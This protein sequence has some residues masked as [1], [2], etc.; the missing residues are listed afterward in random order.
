MK[1]LVSFIMWRSFLWGSTTDWTRIRHRV[2]ESE[3]LAEKHVAYFQLF[4]STWRNLHKLHVIKTLVENTERARG[5]G[6]WVCSAYAGD[7]TSLLLW[8]HLH[9]WW[10]FLYPLHWLDQNLG[11][12]L[13]FKSSLTSCYTGSSYTLAVN[14]SSWVIWWSVG[15]FISFSLAVTWKLLAP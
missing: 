6:W 14:G 7:P 9:Q 13:Q 3:V 15:N 1:G 2:V 8:K 5:P 11:G 4:S 10:I 12:D